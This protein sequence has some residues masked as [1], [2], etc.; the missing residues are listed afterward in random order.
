MQNREHGL[1]FSHEEIYYI[2]TLLEKA[3][4]KIIPINN[5]KD[6]SINEELLKKLRSVI[7]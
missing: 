6:E 4:G 1:E 3:Q 2:V 7:R 5:S